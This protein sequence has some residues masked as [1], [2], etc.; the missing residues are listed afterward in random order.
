MF[1]G[2]KNYNQK[3][4]FDINIDKNKVENIN[5]IFKDATLM[6]KTYSDTLKFNTSDNKQT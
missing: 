4:I 2:C 5:N 3:N 6:N 1:E